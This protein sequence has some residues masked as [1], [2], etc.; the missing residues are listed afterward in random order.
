V[1]RRRSLLDASGPPS[2]KQGVIDG[3]Q[4]VRGTPLLGTAAPP[5]TGSVPG[6]G[7]CYTHGRTA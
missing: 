4:M 2:I 5:P 7:Q 1:C 6:C 3:V